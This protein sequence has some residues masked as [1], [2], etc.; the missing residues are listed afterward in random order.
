MVAERDRADRN[1]INLEWQTD[2]KTD[3]KRIKNDRFG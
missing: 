1:C 3:T 2:T